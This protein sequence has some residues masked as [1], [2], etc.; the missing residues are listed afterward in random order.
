MDNELLT[1][2]GKPIDPTGAGGTCNVWEC[3]GLAE[4]S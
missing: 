3:R 4:N 1:L 2:E